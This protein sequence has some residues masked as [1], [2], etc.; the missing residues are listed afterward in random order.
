MIQVLELHSA[1][2][3]S[4][5]RNHNGALSSIIPLCQSLSIFPIQKTQK[6]S[7]KFGVYL[8][9]IL[10]VFH[11]NRSNCLLFLSYWPFSVLSIHM[12][13][14]ILLECLIIKPMHTGL[15]SLK[16]ALLERF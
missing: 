12:V 14:H 1:Y 2:S 6:Q 11:Q 15:P 3:V 8:S 5:N 16:T 13:K 9:Q 4:C 10:W 7:F